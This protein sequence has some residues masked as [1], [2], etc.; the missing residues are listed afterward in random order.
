MI[1]ITL[2]TIA[3]YGSFVAA[4]QLDFSGVIATVA[5]GMLCGNYAVHTGMSASTRVA[6]ETRRRPAYRMLLLKV[7]P[8]VRIGVSKV[9]SKAGS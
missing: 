8:W 3:A 1:E 7:F 5:A 4:E 9:M 2:T 6:A